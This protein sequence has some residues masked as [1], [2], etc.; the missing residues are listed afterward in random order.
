MRNVRFNV[1]ILEYAQR[2]IDNLNESE[3]GAIRA[4]I[5]AMTFGNFDSVHTKTLR[6]KIREL[7]IGSHRISYFSIGSVLYFIR[8]F[9]K[10]SAK[11]PRKEIEYAEQVYKLM[12]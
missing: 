7:I 1:F 9:R 10:R 2:Y 5:E 12:K 4:D 3:Q 8:G 6:G 11:T